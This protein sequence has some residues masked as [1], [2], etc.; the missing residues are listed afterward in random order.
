MAATPRPIANSTPT[1]SWTAT[2]R[3]PYPVIGAAVCR[4]SSGDV[5]SAGGSDGDWVAAAARYS[6]ATGTWSAAFA[7][8]QTHYLGAL[9]ALDGDQAVIMDGWDEIAGADGSVS[10]ASDGGSEVYQQVL[11]NTAPSFDAGP[12]QEVPENSGA[13]TVPGWATAISPGLPAESS[14]PSPS[15]SAPPTPGCSASRPRST[16]PAP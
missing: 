4:L 16:P 1:A 2:G 15:W 6:S 5:L 8:A 7:M 11:I 12:D 14:R 10:F 9:A 13:H 3:L